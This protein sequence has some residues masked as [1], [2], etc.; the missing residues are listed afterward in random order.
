MIVNNYLDKLIILKKNN[1]DKHFIVSEVL[2]NYF[3]TPFS[4]Y[5]DINTTFDTEQESFEKVLDA[6]NG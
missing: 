5:I 6:I 1:P 4:N 3:F 2:S